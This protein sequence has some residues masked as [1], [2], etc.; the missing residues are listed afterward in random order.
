M[1]EKLVIDI[2]EY[3]EKELYNNIK[4]EEIAQH[5]YFNRYY[6]V[7]TFKKYT[8]LTIN[9]YINQ[10]KIIKS[11]DLLVN[12]DNRILYVALNSGFNSLEYYSEMF[13]KITNFSPLEFRKNE[14][15]KKYLPF[16]YSND[17]INSIENNKKILEN[18]KNIKKSVKV[19]SKTLKK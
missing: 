4:V 5:F 18:I 19:L 3:I 10:R 17:L 13:F 14:Q 6:L 1:T 11:I 8:E 15:V 7:R 16:D 12:T 9:D 2:L